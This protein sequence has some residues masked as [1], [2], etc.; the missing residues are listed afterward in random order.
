MENDLNRFIALWNRCLDG[1]DPDGTEIFNMLIGKYNSPDRYYHTVEHIYQCLL[2]LDSV[3]SCL[4][5]ADNDIVELAIWFHDAIYE[6]GGTRNELKSAQWFTKLA[7]KKMSAVIVESVDRCIMYTTHQELPEDNCSKFMVDIDLSGFGQ[8]WDG[9]TQD[10]SKVRKE[11]SYQSD[12]S[13]IESQTKFM[14]KLLDR[15]HI[16]ST[17]Y[18]N[19]L[20]ESQ[21]RKNITRQLEIYKHA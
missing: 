18:F 14:N 17:E 21:A 10:G 12:Q 19:T 1:E 15:D 8:D 20:L 2:K 16:Y 13:Y 6:I 4:S 7:G 11:N 5:E 3:S 9:F